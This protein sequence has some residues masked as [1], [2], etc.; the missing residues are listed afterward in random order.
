MARKMSMAGGVLVMLA[1]GGL[2][3]G[4]ETLP[5]TAPATR[6]AGTMPGDGKAE[7]LAVVEG[8][9]I[10]AAKF[11]EL[12]GEG[13]RV[14][15]LGAAIDLMLAER[16][17]EF[18]GI[19]TSGVQTG[20]GD[21]GFYRAVDAEVDRAQ[22]EA[23]KAGMTKEEQ[24]RA[25]GEILK[26]RGMSWEEF[27]MTMRRDACLRALAK[28]RV[29]VTEEMVKMVFDAQYGERLHGRL[30]IVRTMLEAS[31]IRKALVDR[32]K[33]IDEVSATYTGRSFVLPM[34]GEGDGIIRKLR[35]VGKTLKENNLSGAVVQEADQTYV[36]FYLERKEP[37][38]ADVKFEALKEGLQK[39]LAEQGQLNWMRAHLRK[40]RGMGKVTI[41]DPVL[42]AAYAEFRKVKPVT[43][44]APT[45]K[46]PSWAYVS[47][48]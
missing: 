1:A 46:A 23:V 41:N 42:A 37:A 43:L 16:A 26:R 22:A 4:A 18:A 39:E 14:R 11:K 27:D 17:C 31:E 13:D 47:G 35:E 19:D 3:V 25:L 32:G 12:V 7:V 45:E 40:L 34:G 2:F 21:R 6:G 38:R 28:D 30:F 24:G 8:K 29:T 33:S 9:E 15:M 20:I 5:T 36:L 48:E 44:P 10:S